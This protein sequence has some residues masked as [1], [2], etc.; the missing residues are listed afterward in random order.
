MDPEKREPLINSEEKIINDGVQDTDTSDAVRG[1]EVY[2]DK[3]EGAKPEV[4]GVDMHSLALAYAKFLASNNLEPGEPTF[5]ETGDVIKENT[6]REETGAAEKSSETLR[7]VWIPED[8]QSGNKDRNTGRNRKEKESG[9]SKDRRKAEIKVVTVSDDEARALSESLERSSGKFRILASPLD[10]IDR[11]QNRVDSTLGEMGRDFVT[12]GHQITSTYRQSRRVIGTAIL[13]TG[14]VVTAILMTFN[15]YTL[16]EYAYNG[17]VLGYVRNQEDVIDVLDIA[18]RELTANSTG[19]TEIKFTP[20][21]NVTFKLCDAKGKSVD[22][23]D[24]A[25]NKLVYMTDIETE[26]YGVYDGDKMVAVVKSE[27]EAERVLEQAKDQLSIPDDGMR[28]VSADYINDLA[29]RPVNVLLT[30]VQSN[31]D[32]VT[33]M[34]EGGTSEIYHIVEENETLGSIADTFRVDRAN[35]FD[36]SNTETVINADP[37]DKVCIHQEI[38][39]VSV[40]MVEKGKMRE[41]IEF[42]TIKKESDDYYRGDTYLEQDG[43]DGIQSFKGTVTKVS[44][45]VT[46][47]KGKTEEIRKKKDKII[48]VGTAERPKTAPTGTYIVPLKNYEGISSP[49]GYRW[50]RLHS[51]ID[52]GASHGTPIYAT[53]GGT[54]Q[55]AGWYYGYGLCVEIDHGNGRMT[56]YGHCSAL[57]VNVGDKV[58]QGQNIALVGN[59]GHSFGNHLHFEINFNGSPVDPRPYLGI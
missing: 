35:I 45:E 39:P 13:M 11:I 50:G 44:G 12:S 43:V 52:M 31:A 15:R 40:K 47:R 28:L 55:R 3:A 26:A 36:E 54:I 58:Y 23:A 19:G 21:Q 51:G 53:D 30:S 2:A 46:K 56:R 16:Y 57:L 27:K 42:E 34:T 14:I 20:N 38:A 29:V 48:L 8:E 7:P 1:K 33:L 9:G 17:K 41:V 10:L 24:V 59:T 4:S 22:S 18:G 5:I 25:V 32:A 49:F 6:A 37:G